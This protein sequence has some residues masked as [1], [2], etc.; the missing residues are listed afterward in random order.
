MVV[1][2]VEFRLAIS[3]TQRP[4]SQGYLFLC[5]PAN[6]RCGPAS[7]QW[8]HYPAYWSLDP[9]GGENLSPE[10]AV[11]LGFPTIELRIGADVRTW[12]ASVYQGISKFYEAK[13]FNPDTEDVA[14]HLRHQLWKLSVEVGVQF[15]DSMIFPFALS[16]NL[17]EPR[18]QLTTSVTVV[19]KLA[20]MLHPT[21][22]IKRSTVRQSIQFSRH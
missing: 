3:G 19:K 17:T 21:T 14:R 6:L 15:A 4:P 18:F 12:D 1:D 9:L 8:P 13:G 10:E 11:Q 7:F 22:R 5:P 2:W 16:A 20:L